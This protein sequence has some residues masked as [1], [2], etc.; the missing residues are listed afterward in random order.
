MSLS[1]HDLKAI[2]EESAPALAGATTQKLQWTQ[3]TGLLI[4]FKT[5]QQKTQ[6]FISLAH[7][8][9][10]AYLA[11]HSP[12]A[13]ATAPTF[14]INAK[15]HLKGRRL[16]E[17]RIASDDRILTLVYAKTK[18]LCNLHPGKP[19]LYLVDENE[20]VIHRWQDYGYARGD[21]F[22]SNGSDAA[23][24]SKPKFVDPNQANQSAEK[25]FTTLFQAKRVQNVRKR[26][27]DEIKKLQK[28]FDKLGSDLKSTEKAPE[29]L[30]KGDLIKN[31]LHKLGPRKLYKDRITIP[32]SQEVVTLDKQQTAVEAM[33]SFYGRY[34]KLQRRKHQL[35]K[36]IQ[37]TEEK[38]NHAQQN[39]QHF[40]ANCHDPEFLQRFEESAD[41]H[42]VVHKQSQ[43]K[44]A[45][46]GIIQ[47]E[48]PDGYT[49]LL[50]KHAEGNEKVL[51]L[52][53]G[54]DYWL[55]AR[56]YSG[57]HCVIKRQGKKEVPEKTIIWAA[58]QAASHSKAKNQT[59]VDVDVALRSD[60]KKVRGGKPGLVKIMRSRTVHVKL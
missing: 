29:V 11:E 51:K 60:V 36:I 59:G 14:L 10:G 56:G 37:S 27:A 18:L 6:F 40:E 15:Q 42:Q 31:N 19:N 53:K 4:H 28:R 21:T 47:K 24:K 26:L 52:A 44:K 46:A 17:L 50:G 2:V 49:I 12:E 25:H 22:Q 32:D 38:L 43:N 9:T 5:R 35:E 48:S 13:C 8:Q 23:K 57:S 3:P 55:H 58:E 41:G 33:E 16:Q 20:V 45:L 34:K 30:R 54:N 1:W 39:L 7:N